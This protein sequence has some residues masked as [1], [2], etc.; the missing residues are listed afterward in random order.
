[1][2]YFTITNHGKNDRLIAASSPVAGHAEL[3]ISR[4]DAG[5]MKMRHLDAVEVKAGSPTVFEPSGKHVMLMGLKKPLKKGESFPLVLKFAK[6]GSVEIQVKVG[7]MGGVAG[8]SE[9]DMGHSTKPA[10]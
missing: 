9:M 1:M 7:D 5:V 3:H 8:H 4:M 10:R 6:A 2:A